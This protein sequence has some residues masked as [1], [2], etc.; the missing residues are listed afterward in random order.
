MKQLRHAFRCFEGAFL[1]WLP[2]VTI[3]AVKALAP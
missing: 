3:L 1:C 2:L